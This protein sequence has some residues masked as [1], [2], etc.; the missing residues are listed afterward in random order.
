MWP[1]PSL[2]RR[3]W[4]RPPGPAGPSCAGAQRGIFRP[5]ARRP[6]RGLSAGSR[7]EARQEYMRCPSASGPVYKSRSIT[8]TGRATK[9]R[10]AAERP[11]RR[12]AGY[13]GPSRRRH[14][15][16][17]RTSCATCRVVVVAGSPRGSL[18]EDQAIEDIRI[19]S[20]PERRADGDDRPLTSPSLAGEGRVGGDFSTEARGAAPRT[21]PVE[22]SGFWDR[23]AARILSCRWSCSC[24]P[25]SP[26]RSATRST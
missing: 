12:V 11:A 20:R 2:P 7:R 26:T 24:W 18:K 13:P 9:L 23:L 8:P 5:P 4:D 21:I 3:P 14:R 22:L 19:R 6:L 15:V 16:K 10:H 1:E 17:A 25:L